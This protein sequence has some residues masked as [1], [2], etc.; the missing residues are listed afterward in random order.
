MNEQLSVGSSESMKRLHLILQNSLSRSLVAW[1][2]QTRVLAVQSLRDH[3]AIHDGDVDEEQEDHEEVVHESQE[4][5]KSLG[6]E[7]ERRREVGD[8]ADE[9][10]KNPDPE[11]PEQAAHRKHLPEGVAEQGGHVSQP[12]HQLERPRKRGEMLVCRE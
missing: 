5:K 4:A 12:V 7:V 1:C 6:D 2:E 8:G 10:E 3:L 11:H 9:A